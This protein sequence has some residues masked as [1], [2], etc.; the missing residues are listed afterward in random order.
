MSLKK[1]GD[2]AIHHK[3]PEENGKVA[4][5]CDN[6][7]IATEAVFDANHVTGKLVRYMMLAKMTPNTIY[8]SSN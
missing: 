2:K 4:E 8:Q 3:V 7:V 1:M 5:Y 6:D